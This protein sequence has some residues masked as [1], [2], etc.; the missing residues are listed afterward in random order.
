LPGTS[1][2]SESRILDPSQVGSA[3]SESGIFHPKIPTGQRNCM[4]LVEKIPGS[5]PEAL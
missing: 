5:R 4:G 3:T 2:G 1:D